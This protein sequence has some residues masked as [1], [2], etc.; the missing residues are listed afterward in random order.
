MTYICQYIT[1]KFNYELHFAEIYPVVYCKL[2]TLILFKIIVNLW[3][4]LGF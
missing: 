4:N 3:R 2:Y 1:R